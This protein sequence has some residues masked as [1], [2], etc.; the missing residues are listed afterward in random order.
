MMPRQLADVGQESTPAFASKEPKDRAQ[1][2]Y[3]AYYTLDDYVL[4]CYAF[5]LIKVSKCVRIWLGLPD[6]G[7][8][9]C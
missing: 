7:M 2:L 5:L 4:C 3:Q 1:G 6:C 8:R 9:D